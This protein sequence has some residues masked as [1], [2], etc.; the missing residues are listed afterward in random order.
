MKK[1]WSIQYLRAFAAVAVVVFHSLES[2][3][4]RFPVG[5]AGVD[6]FFVI[7]GFIITTLTNHR[8]KD[9]T[10]FLYHR[11]VR[12]VPLYW[13]LTIIAFAI[14]LVK[15]NFFYRF[16][17]SFSNLIYSL[18][19]LPHSAAVGRVTPVLQQGWTLEYEMF[20]YAIFTIWLFYPAKNRLKFIAL[21]LCALVIVGLFIPKPSPALLTYTSPLLLEFVAG[22]RL[23]VAW[24]RKLMPP[25]IFG[26]AFI[27]AGF[28]LFCL[29]L[30]LAAP[31]S[32]IMQAI[33]WGGP[34]ALIVFGAL[35]LEAGEHVPRVRL[36]VLLGDAS[37]AIYL[38]H[39][40]VVTAFLWR[41][42]AAPIWGRVTICVVASCL[43]AVVIHLWLERPLNKYLVD[44]YRRRKADRV[45]AR[46]DAEAVVEVQQA[47]APTD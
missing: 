35:S 32:G 37:Y 38:A 44:V 17:A 20:F 40:F 11:L 8:E 43:V 10:E 33:R 13:A 14:G 41:F 24:E 16:D 25:P 46:H 36:G 27:A 6:V 26:L 12:I 9:A 31:S 39:G 18:L 47:P 23:A 3:T 34:A 29:Q 19:F 7:S 4:F 21:I 2:S 30:T 22:I 45:A 1:L 42:S 28:G 15:S 5:A